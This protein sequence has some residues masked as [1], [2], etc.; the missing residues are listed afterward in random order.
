MEA[1]RQYH[2][3]GVSE[4]S[5]PERRKEGE[6]FA[7]AR[8]AISPAS[9][10]ET[11]H[12]P[13]PNSITVKLEEKV[14]RGRD[15]PSPPPNPLE[16]VPPPLGGEEAGANQPPPSQPI[17]VSFLPSDP[18]NPQ[19]WSTAYKS[20]VVFLLTFL[21]LSLTFASSAS[22]SAETGVMED[23]GCGKVAAT[24]TTG[25]FLIGM[26]LGAM[27]AAPLSECTSR[28]LLQR[29]VVQAG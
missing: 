13:E 11:L 10:A 1:W 25:V 28:H 24:A 22:S 17:Y 4:Q 26:G 20:W 18:Q 3:F 12:E 9:T 5:K 29:R 21:T 14:N 15:D 2:A 23:F 16:T 8:T 6:P 19:S 7:P 27:P